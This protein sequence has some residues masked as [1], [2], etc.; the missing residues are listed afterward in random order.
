MGNLKQKKASINSQLKKGVAFTVL[1]N[2]VKDSW[3]S[4][5]IPSQTI[6]PYNWRPAAIFS[7]FV[8]SKNLYVEIIIANR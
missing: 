2:C 5:R 6:G 7:M 4:K 1:R 8:A 3:I